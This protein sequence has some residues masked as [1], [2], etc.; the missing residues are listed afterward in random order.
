MAGSAE[1]G[2]VLRVEVLHLVDEEGDPLADVRGEPADVGE[3]LHEVDLD[4]AES[5]RPDTAGTSM[6]GCH[7]S[8]SLAPGGTPQ[9]E[10]L[11]DAEHVVDLVAA[12]MTQLAN[13]LVGSSRQRPAQPLIGPRLE[14]ACAPVGPHRRRPQGVE[15]DC[16]ADAAETRQ[17]DRPLRPAPRDPL[18]D[19][20]ERPQ[21]L[22]TSGQLGRP[23]P[24]PGAYGLV[25]GSTI[26]GYMRV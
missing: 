21:L 6:P 16:L 24:A 10:R 23:L 5:A 15:Q 13:G 11:D 17:D 2:D 8:R 20:V 7:L 12:R 22:I 26:G 18:E 25:M 14:L 9:R 3:Q 4:V 1:R 19:D